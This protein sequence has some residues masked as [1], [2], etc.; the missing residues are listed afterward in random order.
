MEKIRSSTTVYGR[1]RVGR[2]APS[3]THC[4]D[5]FPQTQKII[6]SSGM[7][8]QLVMGSLLTAGFRLDR[9]QGKSLSLKDCS[10]EQLEKEVC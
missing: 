10:R 1:N 2:D 4:S 3:L 6:S 7:S 9:G 5:I 8:C